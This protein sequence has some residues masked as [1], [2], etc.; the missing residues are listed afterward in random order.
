[1][2]YDYSRVHNADWN[3]GENY[4]IKCRDIWDNEPDGCG[5]IVSPKT[6]DIP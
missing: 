1:M 2:S 4:H 3:I 5:I 6:L